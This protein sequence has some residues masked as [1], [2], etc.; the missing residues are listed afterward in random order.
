MSFK[1]TSTIYFLSVGLGSLLLGGCGN[2]DGSVF[3]PNATGTATGTGS[4]SMTGGTITGGPGSGAGGSI[5]VT[6]TGTGSGGGN[7]DVDSGCANQQAGT[8]NIPTDI[9]IMLDRSGSML[10]PAA[11]D[12]CTDPMGTP[13]EPTRWTAV[14]NAI[15]GFVGSMDS[16]GIGVGIGF[17]A[18]ENGTFVDG[19]PTPP[20]SCNVADYARPTVA[21]APL[22]GNAMPVSNAIAMTAPR[23]NTPTTPALTGAINYARAYTAATQGRTAAVVLVTDGIP[24]QCFPNTVTTATNAAQAGFTG[25]PSIKTY[26]VGLGRTATLDSIALAGSGGLTHY[27]PAT[28][29]VTAQLIAALKQI[30]GAISCDYAIPTGRPLD[31]AAVAIEI[32]V[33]S[34]GMPTLV[35]RVDNAAACA[36][37]TNGWFFDSNPPATP[38]KITLCPQ[39]CDPLKTN[40][41]STIKL[42]IG[43]A[44]VPPR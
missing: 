43:C 4:G 6:G 39:T 30:S 17:F 19:G 13:V 12:A 35:Q 25:N 29:D 28:G 32:K 24:T 3:D 9:F 27:F 23:N 37:A 7:V 36:G 5:N 14:T 16:A 20:I 10:C 1:R 42:V 40:D 34:S 2:K 38:T 44:G 18:I 21:I 33:G 8:T 26:V 11:Q 15:N 31:Y 41:G 22:P